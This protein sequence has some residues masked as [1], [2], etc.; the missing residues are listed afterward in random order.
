MMHCMRLLLAL[1]LAGTVCPGFAADTP[2]EELKAVRGRIE[3]LE[4][5]IAQKEQA[6]QKAAKAVKSSDQEIVGAR[7]KLKELQGKLKTLQ[8]QMEEL[9]RQRASLNDT[10][11]QQRALLAALVHQQYL[12]GAPESLQLVFTGKDASDVSRNLH[13]LSYVSKSRGKV[14]GDLRESLAQLDDLAVQTQTKSKELE[15]LHSETEK[16]RKRLEKERHAREGLLNQVATDLQKRKDAVETLKKDE[17]RLASLVAHLARE[18]ARKSKHK[19]KLNLKTPEPT[20]DVAFGSL[21]GKLRLPVIGELTNRFGSPRSD[22]GLSWKGLVI[23]TQSAEPVKA[24]AA[25]EVAYAGALRG[26]GKLLILDH[27]EGFMS[28]YGYNQ[29]LNR[30]VGDKVN[31]GDTI[32]IAGSRDASGDSGLY[33]ELRVQGKPVDPMKWMAR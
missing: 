7:R 31:G 17:Q 24:I 27:G 8:S 2:S 3:Q 12:R 1:L 28:L 15:A 25:G 20:G 33:F 13:Y 11:A 19:K 29:S 23:A 16:E 26:F 9:E 18:L 14:I 21:K 6:R 10:L 22:T 5:E 30:K 32:A 4:K